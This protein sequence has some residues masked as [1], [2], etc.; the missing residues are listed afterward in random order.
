MASQN[1]FERGSKWR[2]W[3]LH[4]HAPASFHWHGAKFDADPNSANNRSLV[5]ENDRG[6]ERWDPAVFALMDYWTFDGWF[7]LKRRLKEAGAPQL[8]KRV[9]PGIELRL[10]A[11]M[12]T[13]N[14]RLNAHVLFSDE[15]PD[16]S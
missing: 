4:V 6:H 16:Q 12:K 14:G 1:A 5:D 3:D 13:P 10:M 11:P 8:H 7:A 9:F 15:I 2:Q